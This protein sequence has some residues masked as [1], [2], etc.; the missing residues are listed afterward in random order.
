MDKP[1]RNGLNTQKTTGYSNLSSIPGKI[2]TENIQ[3][4]QNRLKLINE[5][6]SKILPNISSPNKLK[7]NELSI[8][9]KN[10]VELLKEKNIILKNYVKLLN[11]KNITL[12]K[13]YII[14]SEIAKRL[15][16]INKK[17]LSAPI[18]K[19][20][21]NNLEKEKE[22]LQKQITLSNK[23][24]KLLNNLHKIEKIILKINEKLKTSL[25]NQELKDA[26]DQ[27]LIIKEK[28]KKNLGF[29]ELMGSKL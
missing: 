12:N 6:L 2:E 23:N 18:T 22:N 4:S 1:I 19:S 5:K 10:Y 15:N 28:I 27:A 7:P 3:N 20:Q 9:I 25:K 21:K 11:E 14:E 29:N 24:I 26:R 17:L 8:L 13:N 16:N